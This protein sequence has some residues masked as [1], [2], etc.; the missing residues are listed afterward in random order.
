MIKSNRLLSAVLGLVLVTA[1]ISHA[2][3]MPSLERYYTPDFAQSEWLTKHPA[4]KGQKH[5]M[6]PF[7]MGNIQQLRNYMNQPLTLMS[8]YRCAEHPVEAIK[9]TPGQHNKGLAVDIYVTSGAM[10]YQI[11][12]Y[13]LTE[14]DVR[15][16]AYSKEGG[17]VHLDW[18]TGVRVTWNY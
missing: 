13:A 3:I 2:G 10:A 6:Q 12:H 17:F 4:C 7:V 11:I 18:R 1:N 16:F 8:A 14:L 5:Q 9:E 15:G